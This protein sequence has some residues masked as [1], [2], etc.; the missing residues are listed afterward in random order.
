MKEDPKQS[1]RCTDETGYPVTLICHGGWL[2]RASEW[3]VS[4]AGG[5]RCAAIVMAPHPLWPP[6]ISHRATTSEI[7]TT[8]ATIQL[9]RNWYLGQRDRRGVKRKS[10]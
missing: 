6:T 9:G 2:F 7:L 3:A 1:N 8:G 10:H 5:G 4:A